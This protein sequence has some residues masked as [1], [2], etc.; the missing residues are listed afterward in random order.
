[1]IAHQQ[2]LSSANYLGRSRHT[3]TERS[4]GLCRAGCSIC[5]SSYTGGIVRLVKIHHQMMGHG[6]VR[7]P[8]PPATVVYRGLCVRLVSGVL[9]ALLLV[10]PGVGEECLGQH[11]LGSPACL[12]LPWCWSL[13]LSAT[14]SKH[15]VCSSPVFHP[16]CST[17]LGQPLQG[18]E[19]PRANGHAPGVTRAQTW[20]GRKREA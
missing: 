9:L 20:K 18:K 11:L 8:L 1:M 10:A 5:T 6:W 17:Y 3:R 7:P 16:L 14:S 19:E 13:Q 12:P 15:W 2:T 4:H